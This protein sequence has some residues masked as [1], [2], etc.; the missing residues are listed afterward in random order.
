[1]NAPA[2]LP[3]AAVAPMA[4]S[5][6]ALLM[7]PSRFE[8]MCRVGKMFAVSPLFPEHL[9][10]K[11][12]DQGIA[13]AVLVLNMANR[14]NEDPLTVA[15]NI[16]FVGGRPG[17]NTTYMI[18]KANL[19]GVFKDVIDWEVKG[20]GETLAV[21]AFATI[22]TTGRRVQVTCDMEMAKKEGWIK[23]A[24]YQSIPEQMLRYRSAAFLIRLYCPEV[25]IG[26]PA[27]IELELGGTI[28]VTPDG[29]PVVEAN[30]EPPIDATAVQKD[31]AE[32]QKRS[33]VDMRRDHRRDEVAKMNEGKPQSTS[34]GKTVEQGR[35]EA[36]EQKD[37]PAQEDAGKA[38]ASLLSA[39]EETGEVQPTQPTE[40]E[41]E[42]FSGVASMIVAD[43]ESGTDPEDIDQLYG[44]QIEILQKRFPELMAM[45]NNAFLARQ[46]R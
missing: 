41:I 1:M 43:I 12:I 15:Q 14:L 28:D 18:A 26:V 11:S 29:G 25:M 35:S 37:E 4:N 9:R 22:R 42:R 2:Q 21:T 23:N 10:G 8:H 16:Y 39:D 36:E 31:A 34:G 19:H 13:N 3:A 5:P 32:T 46:Q 6:I 38:Q 45:V 33:T 20:K 27:S 24:K 17:W 40:E 7:D 30:D 44:P